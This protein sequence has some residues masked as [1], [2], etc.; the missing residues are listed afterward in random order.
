M[1]MGLAG[2]LTAAGL[3][4]GGASPTMFRR[5][6][7]AFGTTVSLELE[8]A[9]ASRAE[10]GFAAGFAEIRRI[11]R[12]AGLA[13][14]D[15]EVFR[16][17]RDGELRDPSPDLLA[18]LEMARSMH[19]ATEGAFDVTVQPLWLALDAAARQ[20]RWLSEAE[21]AERLRRVDQTRIEFD[22]TRIRFAAP[23][24]QITLN[25]LARGLAEDKV[26]IALARAGVT[27]AFF[28]TDVLGGAGERPG[29]GPWRASLRHP[30]DAGA[31]LGI[32]DL[33]GCLAT[34]GD[35]AYAWSPDYSRHHIL[36]ARLGASPPDFAGVSVLA[37]SGLLADALSTAAFLAGRAGG[38]ALVRRF[39]AEAVFVDKAG[40]T[41]KT[42]G[43]P[44]TTLAG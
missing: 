22:A 18:M 1:G 12:L 27:R 17:N 4:G 37:G 10:A 31:S 42:P 2:G 21:I 32:A 13:R 35:Y 25:S 39:G 7:V 20:G 28:N 23:G 9:D 3:A 40:A 29:G 8:A 24:M 30:R 34:S 14:E 44:L 11:D 38:E 15:G 41:T 26:A 16:L 6:G 19:D 36:D 5:L 43:F 33:R